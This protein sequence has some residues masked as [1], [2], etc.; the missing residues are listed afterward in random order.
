VEDITAKNPE[1]FQDGVQQHI[2]ARVKI[3]GANGRFH[4]WLAM[5]TTSS[6]ELF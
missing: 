6:K 2:G 4:K 1:S 5:S 3:A